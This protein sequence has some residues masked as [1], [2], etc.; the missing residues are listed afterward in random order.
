MFF[1]SGKYILDVLYG[2][3][4]S[5]KY[6]ENLILNQKYEKIG[7]KILWG[8]ERKINNVGKIQVFFGCKK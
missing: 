6:Q 1:A 3:E 2:M 7:E 5:R 4:F 8:F